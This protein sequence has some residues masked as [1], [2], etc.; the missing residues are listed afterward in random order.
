MKHDNKERL[1]NKQSVS[2]FDDVQL[3]KLADTFFGDNRCFIIIVWRHIAEELDYVRQI[4]A[5]EPTQT[6]SGIDLL[7]ILCAVVAMYEHGVCTVPPVN[8]SY[9]FN[10]SNDI[11][12]DVDI[13]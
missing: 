11:D 13:N 3:N 6:T 4:Y 1:K 9:F 5:F 12:S 7:V 2:E 10:G 8:L